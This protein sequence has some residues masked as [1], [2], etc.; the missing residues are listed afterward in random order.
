MGRA[1]IRGGGWEGPATQ[2]GR[3]CLGERASL[4]ICTVFLLSLLW[5]CRRNIADFTWI[6]LFGVCM[7]LSV[8]VCTLYRRDGPHWRVL[9]CLFPMLSSE[10]VSHWTSKWPVGSRALPDPTSPALE[11]QVHVPAPGFYMSS[12]GQAQFWCLH[13]QHFTS[14]SISQ[15]LPF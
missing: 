12:R 3:A 10:M 14:G 15:H 7:C 9:P 5:W 13:A 8:Y 11:F 4:G 1:E 2:M 6:F